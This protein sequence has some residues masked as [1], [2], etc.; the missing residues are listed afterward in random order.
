M[1]KLFL[2]PYKAGSRSVNALAEA[3]P[4]KVIKLQRSR[5]RNRRGNVVINW[6][7]SAIDN[8][9]VKTGMLLNRPEVVAVASNKLDFFHSLGQKEWLVPFTTDYHEAAKWLADGSDVVARHV[10]SGHSG[11]GIEI[12]KAGTAVKAAPLYT[13]YMKKTWEF[14][15]HVF[16]RPHAEIKNIDLQWKRKR[17]GEEANFQVRNHE[18]GWVFAREGL[19]DLNNEFIDR[20]N[21]LAATVLQETQLDF[22]AVDIIYNQKHDKLYA[23][24]INTAPGLEGTTLN[25]YVSAFREI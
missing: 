20:V 7:S 6:G 15:A 3:L 9:Q 18:N 13:K 2:Y 12:L 4:A 21:T 23:L 24:E 17:N 1:S 5:Y 22:G 14:R 11:N 25:S 19:A 8:N 16:K 10:L